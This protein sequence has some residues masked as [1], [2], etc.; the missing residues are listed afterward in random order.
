M[1]TTDGLP[2]MKMYGSTAPA[3]AAQVIAAG[4]LIK[5]TDASLARY[6]NV[7]AAF[8]AGYTRVLRTNGEEHLLHNGNPAAYAGLNPQ[9]PS[10]LVY[11]IDVP[12]HAPILLGAMYI[13]NGSTNGPQV[14]G[15][16]T[17][18]HSHLVVCQGGRPT[19]AGFGVQLRGSCNPATFT[20]SYTSQMLHVWVVPYPGGPFSDDLSRAATNAAARAALAQN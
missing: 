6:R 17:R 9:H 20:A 3:T 15:G 13:E 8:A 19:V 5:A 16:L 12:H 7:Q 4:Q 11:A 14:G 2:D 10:S 18:W 1:G